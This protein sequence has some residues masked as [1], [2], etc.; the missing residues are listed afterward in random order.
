MA[1]RCPKKTESGC[2]GWHS[3][4]QADIPSLGH[5]VRPIQCPLC[6]R[7]FSF[8][9]ITSSVTLVDGPAGGFDASQLRKD[10]QEVK[11]KIESRRQSVVKQR[12]SRRRSSIMFVR[13]YE[14]ATGPFDFH[15]LMT[16]CTGRKR[17]LKRVG[18]PKMHGRRGSIRTAPPAWTL[19]GLKPAMSTI[20]HGLPLKLG[21]R[22]K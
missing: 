8:G 10:A 3:S 9:S 6:L 1:L 7:G 13:K 17:A 5:R 21:P 16:Y 4:K 19:N 14:L 20:R 22:G 2:S 11:A 18:L 12:L 15:P